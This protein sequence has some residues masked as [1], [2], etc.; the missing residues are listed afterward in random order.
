MNNTTY[1][2]ARIYERF[3][4]IGIT[5]NMQKRQK[6]HKEG[7]CR[8][9]NRFNKCDKIKEIRYKEI[10]DSLYEKRFKH[11]PKFKKLKMI[12]SWDRWYC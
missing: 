4:Y 9:T 12:T 1:I 8:S 6:E 10:D 11:I 2:Y 7:N 3:L 5:K